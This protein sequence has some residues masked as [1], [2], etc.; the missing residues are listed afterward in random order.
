MKKKILLI[1]VEVPSEII[2]FTDRQTCVL[3]GDGAGAV[4]LEESNNHSGVINCSL[5]SDGSK[6]GFL[7]CE[8]KDT[9][10]ELIRMTEGE[11]V[12]KLAIERMI[13]SSKKVIEN[14]N[15]Q[16]SEIS[17]VI[18]HQAN[19]RIIKALA[20]KLKISMSKFVVNIEK[21]GN[22]M[23]ASIPIALREA[24]DEDRI[25]P[26]DYILFSAFGAGLTWGSVLLKW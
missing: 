17:L 19:L 20:E 1:G 5:S 21:Y 8:R 11:K 6:G 2:D 9:G 13:S 22:T 7:Y 23:V 12:F 24:L 10:E 26:G 25:K 18:P 15:I 3:F 16:M 4:V 14:S